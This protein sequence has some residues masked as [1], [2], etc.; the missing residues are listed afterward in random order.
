MMADYT[1]N[2]YYDVTYDSVSGT[3][4]ISGAAQNFN[5]PSVNVT[6]GETD[7]TF[8]AGDNITYSDGTPTDSYVGHF[9][10]GF[11]TIDAGGRYYFNTMN[12]TYAPGTYA[13]DNGPM[14]VCFQRGTR[15]LLADGSEKAVEDLVVGDMLATLDGTAEPVLWVGC[16]TVPRARGGFMPQHLPIRIC[17]GALDGQLPA[18]DLVVSPGHAIGFG[19]V[20]IPARA[21]V[22]GQSIV[23]DFAE[24]Q[25]QYW[26]VR[27]PRHT[28]LMSEGVASESF[29]HHPKYKSF[30]QA[31]EYAARFPDDIHMTV[32]EAAAA[33]PDCL[34]R[35]RRGP[36]AGSIK[37]AIVAR[38][39][40]AAHEPA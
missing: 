35:V 40:S 2:Y 13:I 22:N 20:M 32:D 7:N 11:L 18:R 37:A 33:Y 29:K 12:N 24:T 25:V 39:T 15:L 36:R 8:E 23:I 1:S 30:D 21:L 3:M 34:P 14:P 10:G 9:D 4:T 6:D 31:A 5:T 27:L 38:M 28:M 17:A 26:H 19:D 16:T